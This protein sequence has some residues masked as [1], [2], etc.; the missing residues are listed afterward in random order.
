MSKY[1]IDSSIGFLFSHANLALLRKINRSFHSAGFDITIEQMSLLSCL[2]FEDGKTQ[3]ELSEK[4][5]KDK[6][7]ITKVIDSL[8]KRKLVKRVSDKNDRRLKRIHITKKGKKIV[9]SLRKI[10][11]ETLEEAFKGINKKDIEIFKSV[12]SSINMNLTNTDLLKFINSNI[13]RWN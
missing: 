5:L 3:K 9:P 8:V 1:K 7:S 2:Y 13:G 11:K 10:I 6:V 12:L 4:N